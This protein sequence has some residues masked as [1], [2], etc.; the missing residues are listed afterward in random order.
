MTI[1]IETF[2]PPTNTPEC[3]VVRSTLRIQL[4][5]DPQDLDHS[6]LQSPHFKPSDKKGF[7]HALD[8]HFESLAYVLREVQFPE[9]TRHC[10]AVVNPETG[11]VRYEDCRYP[12]EP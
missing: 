11:E 9:D 8:T 4:S 12:D 10:K 7:R 6:V 2:F 5:A 3:S 1:T